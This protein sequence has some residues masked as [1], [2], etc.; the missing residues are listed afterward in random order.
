MSLPASVVATAPVELSG[1]SVQVRSLT[2]GEV[3]Q[4]RKLD[5]DASDILAISLATGAT[6]AEATEWFA[7][8]LAGDLVRLMAAV[9]TASGMDEAATF[10]V[11]AGDDAGAAATT[12]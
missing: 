11:P 3:R 12:Q 2:I 8:A 1:G 7:Q 6:M 4:C 9:F 5:A 10:P